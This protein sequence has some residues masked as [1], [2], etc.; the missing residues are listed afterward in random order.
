[1]L[2]NADLKGV[3]IFLHENILN[4]YNF[5]LINLNYSSADKNPEN[6]LSSSYLSAIF[7]FPFNSINDVD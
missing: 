4:F 5:Q 7:F 1:M 2:K 3:F 6:S